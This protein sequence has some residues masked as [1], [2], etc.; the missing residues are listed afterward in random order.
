MYHVLMPIDTDEKRA[1][2]QAQAVKALPDAAEAVEVTLLYVGEDD[3]TSGTLRE[4]D[5]GERAVEF[6][7]DDGPVATLETEIRQGDVAEEILDAAAAHDVDLIVLGGRKRSPMGSLVFGSVSTD[8][9]TNARRP[10]MI[11]GDYLQ[12][13]RDQPLVGQEQD[14]VHETPRHSPD[15]PGP[16]HVPGGTEKRSGDKDKPPEYS[17][18][19]SSEHL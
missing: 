12:S 3:Q 16:Y 14:D 18:D 6:L 5:A 4:L 17:D 7:T 10:V 15:E 2:A 8:V 1:H 19:Q 13:E 11:T 9:L